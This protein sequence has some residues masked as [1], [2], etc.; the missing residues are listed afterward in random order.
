LD[1]GPGGVG[2]RSSAKPSN[3]QAAGED[4]A[5]L[6]LP[7]GHGLT[8]TSDRHAHLRPRNFTERGLSKLEVDLSSHEAPVL[9]LPPRSDSPRD[10]G[11]NLRIGLKESF[12]DGR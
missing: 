1:T 11:H 9:K 7:L 6:P 3:R 5:A 4:L 2:S 10:V 12:G 8:T